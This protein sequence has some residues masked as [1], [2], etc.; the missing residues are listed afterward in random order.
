MSYGDGGSSRWGQLG[1]GSEDEDDAYTSRHSFS[2]LSTTKT[3]TRSCESEM[4]NDSGLGNS[5]KATNSI[6]SV[7]DDNEADDRILHHFTSE[8]HSFPH[9]KIRSGCPLNLDYDEVY[10][11]K[12]EHSSQDINSPRSDFSDGIE[13]QTLPS[14]RRPGEDSDD[15]F[16]FTRESVR[17]SYQDD[18]KTSSESDDEVSDD[19]YKSRY[20]NMGYRPLSTETPQFKTYQPTFENSRN[21]WDPEHTP[22]LQANKVDVDK[23]INFALTEGSSKYSRYPESYPSSNKVRIEKNSYSKRDPPFGRGPEQLHNVASSI[24]KLISCRSSD[25]VK[26]MPEG[27]KLEPL[28]PEESKRKKKKKKGTKGNYVGL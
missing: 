7:S 3:S 16:N 2:L 15:D 26:N 11:V 6:G 5:S 4:K 10:E 17:S 18:F 28:Q 1:E 25:E 19:R 21:A 8:D 27:R 22:S 24:D 9:V 14:G 13:L 12:S 20:Y 23:K